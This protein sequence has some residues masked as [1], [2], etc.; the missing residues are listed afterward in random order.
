ML[1]GGVA[2][3]LL[4][5]IVYYLGLVQTDWTAAALGPAGL[6]IW[7]AAVESGIAS[8]LPEEHY[9]VIEQLDVGVIVADPEGRIVSANAA[10]SHCVDDS[11]SRAMPSS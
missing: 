3:P 7:F 5:N 1:V 4:A 9:D 2:L 11:A 6:L 10:A 8:R